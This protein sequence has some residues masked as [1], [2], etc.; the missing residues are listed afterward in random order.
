MTFTALT[1]MQLTIAQCILI[2]MLYT[3]VYSDLTQM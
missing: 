3:G 1:A 2:D